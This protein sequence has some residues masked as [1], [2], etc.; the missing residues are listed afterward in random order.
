MSK[1]QIQKAVTQNAMSAVPNIKTKTLRAKTFRRGLPV[2]KKFTVN[3]V[4]N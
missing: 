1:A 2:E 4:Q 3:Y